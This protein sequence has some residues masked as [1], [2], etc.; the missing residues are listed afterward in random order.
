M[1]SALLTRKA[2]RTEGKAE[3]TTC[4]IRSTTDEKVNSRVYCVS[5]FS[6]NRASKASG[7]SALSNRLGREERIEDLVEIARRN[8]DA[9]ILKLDANCAL[10]ILQLGS[11]ADRECSGFIHCIHGVDAHGQENLPKFAAVS[12]DWGASW[13]Q[14]LDDLEL[15]EALVVTE[16]LQSLFESFVDPDFLFQD[17]LIPAETK[18]VADDAFTAKDFTVDDLQVFG[19]VLEGR[20]FG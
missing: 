15:F 2:A 5:A 17:V 19:K 3:V 9:S 7:V 12:H 4:P 10:A 1:T 8:A 6:S 14:F 13:I 20:Y 11:C 16:E 18:Q